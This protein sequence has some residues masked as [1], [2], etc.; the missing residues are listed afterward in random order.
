[1][2]GRIEE[3]SASFEAR[4]APRSYP[5]TGGVSAMRVLPR[6]MKSPQIL[7]D[8]AV[9]PNLIRRESI[10]GSEMAANPFSRGT[11]PGRA[12]PRHRASFARGH[13]KHGGRQT[14]TPNAISPR[15]RNAIAAA[16]KR[17]ARGAPRTRYHW[18]RVMNKNP[19]ISE[20]VDHQG[21][22]TQAGAPRR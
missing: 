2:I 16:A 4:S 6:W 10:I 12:R 11:C 3:T 18:Q 5:T 19:L 15:A 8:S 1:M 7:D 14:G 22:F 9:R 20:A 13:A 17:L 21:Q